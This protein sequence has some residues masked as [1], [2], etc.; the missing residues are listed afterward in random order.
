MTTAKWLI[1]VACALALGWLAGQARA[2]A[3]D[4]G[5]MVRLAKLTIDPAQLDAYQAALKEEIEDSVRLEPGVL[6][7]YAVSE[8]DRPT[9][10]TILEIYATRAAYQ[11]HIKTPHFLKYKTGTEK[12]VRSL[13]L[14]ETRPL[15]PG[16]KIK[17]DPR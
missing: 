10:L 1:L 13:E 12:M 17:D 6:T 7:L 2:T 5:Q 11:Q 4:G 15:I 16:M 8:I 3:D 14:V 9:H